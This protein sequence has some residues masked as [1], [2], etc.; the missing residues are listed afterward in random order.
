MTFTY[1]AVSGNCTSDEATVTIIL[2]K[3]PWH[4]KNELYIAKCGEDK[5]VGPSQ[6][7][8]AN[9]GS[10]TAVVH[11][12]LITIDPAYGTIEVEEDGSFVYHAAEDIN[13][14]TYVLFRYNATNGVCLAKYQ[15]IAKIQVSC[16]CE[17]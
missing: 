13:S 17:Q 1:Q 2:A 10:A 5:V 14:G 8:L 11:P 9:D 3:C 6:G 16:A 12:E 15:G 4:V 7:I